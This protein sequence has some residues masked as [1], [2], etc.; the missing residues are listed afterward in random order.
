MIIL[1]LVL[2]IVSIFA[3]GSLANSYGTTNNRSDFYSSI[4]G[5][6]AGVYILISMIGA[7][8]E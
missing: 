1:L 8:V 7:I 4:I 2:G 5:F 6:V 3:A